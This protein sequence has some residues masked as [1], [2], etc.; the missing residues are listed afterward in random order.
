MT[1]STPRFMPYTPPLAPSTL[2]NSPFP[3]VQ[4]NDT[5]FRPSAPSSPN[6]Q[7]SFYSAGMFP[8]S[9]GVQS[10]SPSAQGP[11]SPVLSTSPF[12]ND[13]WGQ[14]GLEGQ[15][16][17]GLG[18]R[19]LDDRAMWTIWSFAKDQK[20]RIGYW[21]TTLD[22]YRP[23]SKEI[24]WADVSLKA[25]TLDPAEPR[26][27]VYIQ[28]KK[29]TSAYYYRNLIVT[30]ASLKDLTEYFLLLPQRVYEVGSVNEWRE[31]TTDG[32]RMEGKLSFFW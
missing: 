7:S 30:D 29:L 9:F 8:Q 1:I 19:E 15:N 21:S 25:K 4:F 17:P 11:S 23:D 6:A 24:T 12:A 18:R 13:L 26:W 5:S 31:G 32:E 2:T 28:Y 27:K 16:G 3:N 20:S 22:L 10:V 14:F